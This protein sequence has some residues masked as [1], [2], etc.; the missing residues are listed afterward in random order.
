MEKLG[1]PSRK[2]S[3]R[4]AGENASIASGKS[5]SKTTATTTSGSSELEQ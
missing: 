3:T 5:W 1:L 4:L 2:S